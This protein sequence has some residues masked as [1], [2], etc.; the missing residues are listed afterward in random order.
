MAAF[1]RSRHTPGLLLRHAN[2]HCPV[3]DITPRRRLQV[4]KALRWVNNLG[5]A[6]PGT[7]ALAGRH[8]A[9]RGHHGYGHLPAA[10]HGSRRAPAVAP[11]PGASCRSRLRRDH[12]ST[13]P[14]PA[15]FAG[16]ATAVPIDY[17]L[18]AIFTA[19]AITGSVAGS[20]LGHRLHGDHLKKAFGVFLL[21]VATYTLIKSVLFG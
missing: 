20:I 11:A 2:H 19:I 17:G 12:R 18:M 16:Y 6:Q 1:P 21:F 7:A 3:G 8:G 14:S 4:S 10:C 13:L 15:G 9:V 5:L